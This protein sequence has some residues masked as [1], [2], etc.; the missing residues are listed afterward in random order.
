[1]IEIAYNILK[2]RVPHSFK[3]HKKLAYYAKFVR[4]L[5][6]IRSEHKARQLLQKGNGPLFASLLIPILTTVAGQLLSS[7]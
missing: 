2:H 6:K 7:S 1:M 4:K 3:Q 5:G